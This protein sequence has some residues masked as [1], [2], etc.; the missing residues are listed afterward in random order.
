MPSPN[1][2]HPVDGQK[3]I[4]WEKNPHLMELRIQ[5]TNMNPI[6]QIY[7]YEMNHSEGMIKA[8]KTEG[9]GLVQRKRLWLRRELPFD[10]DLKFWATRTA[11]A[12]A[13][14][15]LVA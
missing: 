14:R 3:T 9:N 2:A 8:A 11:C 15:L 5:R 12:K 7:N 1:P 4:T 6:T 13:L 10:L